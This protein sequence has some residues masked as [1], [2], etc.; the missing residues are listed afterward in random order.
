[1]SEKIKISAKTSRIAV[2]VKDNDSV[3]LKQHDTADDF[4][5]KQLEQYYQQGFN[6]GQKKT[7]EELEQLF[8]QSLL[9][10]YAELN[11]VISKLD[12]KI[13][14]YEKEFENLVVDLSFLLAEAV[15]RRE[16]EKQS[17][18]TITLK[19]AVKKILG[20]NE[21]IIK[22]NPDDHQEIAGSAD[23]IFKDDSFSRIKFEAD[24]RIEKGGCFVET[25]IGNVDARLSTQLNELKR[26]F[27]SYLSVNM[28]Q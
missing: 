10:K 13:L 8:T 3:K 19:D 23:A 9:D 15:T 12:E 25:E 2:T 6:E 4:I 11:I 7:R 18:I 21:V 20:A 27:D 1:M 17:N 5:Q 14:L 28:A 16:I 24:E 22:L 26:Q